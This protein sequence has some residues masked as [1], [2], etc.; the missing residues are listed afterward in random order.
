MTMLHHVPTVAAQDALLAEACRVLRPGGWFVGV[1]SLDDPGFRDFHAGDVCTARRSRRARAAAPRRRLHGDRGRTRRRRVPLRRSTDDTTEGADADA[2]DCR[3]KSRS[4]PRTPGEPPVVPEPPRRGEPGGEP[5]GICTGE[6]TERRVVRRRT[7]RSTR[8]SAAACPARC[9]SPAASHVDSF[10]DLPDE[11]GERTS[12]GS[13]ARVERADP[14]PRR[15]RARPPVPVGRRR[16][17]LPLCGLAVTARDA[18]GLRGQMLPL[19]EDVLPN[20]PD[21]ELA[22]AARQ[23]A[24]AMDG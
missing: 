16:R 10:A 12:A 21:E 4:S 22:E 3:T 14:R 17:A 8:R 5:C 18:R 2:C 23:V 24:A 11:A 9:G 1:D 13:P 7:G 20:V 19:W 6:A 15:R